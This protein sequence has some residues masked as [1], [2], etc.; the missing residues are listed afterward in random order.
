MLGKK[1]MLHGEKIMLHGEE[2]PCTGSYDPSTL[3][4]RVY[5]STFSAFST[6]IIRGEEKAESEKIDQ[7][8]ESVEKNHCI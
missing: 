1:I 5:T 4:A 6:G 7:T 8:K 3:P 2:L